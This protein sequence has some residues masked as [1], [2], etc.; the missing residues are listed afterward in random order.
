MSRIYLVSHAKSDVPVRFVRATSKNAAVRA[1]AAELFEVKAASADDIVSASQSG[2]LDILDA[3]AQTDDGADPGPV[4]SEERGD[5]GAPWNELRDPTKFA[6]L[7]T[8]MAPDGGA[9]PIRAVRA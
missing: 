8:Q 7:T 3:L 9:T 4:P 6:D 2:T 1:V 5:V